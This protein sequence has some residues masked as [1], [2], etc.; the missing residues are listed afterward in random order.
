MGPPAVE[1]LCPLQCLYV[2]RGNV[3]T[4]ERRHPIMLWRYT[5]I[6][7]LSPFDEGGAKCSEAVGETVR[8][9]F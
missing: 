1:G 2:L 7:V 3:S 4:F 9:C 8:F 5:V 6:V